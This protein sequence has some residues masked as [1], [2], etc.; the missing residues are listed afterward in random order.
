MLTEGRNGARCFGSVGE[1][2][3]ASGSGEHSLPRATV[4]LVLSREVSG[5]TGAGGGQAGVEVP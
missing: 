1:G 2:E 4:G 5:T 3:E